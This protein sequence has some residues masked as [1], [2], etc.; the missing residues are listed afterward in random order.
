MLYSEFRRV[1]DQQVEERGVALRAIGLATCRIVLDASRATYF[2]LG[3][4]NDPFVAVIS[5]AEDE[6][7]NRQHALIIAS[8]L[9]KPSSA[10]EFCVASLANAA[11]RPRLP[12]YVTVTPVDSMLPKAVYVSGDPGSLLVDGVPT[13][14]EAHC[15]VLEVDRRFGSV[16]P[17]EATGET[18]RPLELTS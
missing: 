15:Q 9:P 18:I 17:S 8:S 10:P 1:V 16:R 2:D 13:F 3:A 5:S 12:G 4:V 6:A 7:V 11:A 14:S